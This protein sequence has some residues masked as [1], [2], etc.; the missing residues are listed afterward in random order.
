ML[1]VTVAVVVVEKRVWAAG[2]CQ[3]RGENDDGRAGTT[4]K[5]D[6]C[7]KGL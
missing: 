7:S 2:R 5:C 6:K 3:S 4:L 1:A